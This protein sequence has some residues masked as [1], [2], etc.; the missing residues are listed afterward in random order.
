MLAERFFS[1]VV[2]ILVSVVFILVGGWVFALGIS[3]LLAVAAWE[4]A[5]LFLKSGYTPAR[6]TLTIG[7]FLTSLCAST[8]NQTLLELA[9]GL[10]ITAI[11]AC[12]VITYSKHQS[13]AGFDLSASLAGVVFITFI[14]SFLIR[15][16]FRDLGM[17]WIAQCIIPAGIADVGAL[18]LG[19]TLGRHKIAPELSPNK[20]V[21]GYFGGVFTSVLIGYGLGLYFNGFSPVFSGWNG[22]LI[23]LAVGLISPLG[24]FAKSIFKRQFGLKNTGNLIPGHGGVLDRIDTWLWAGLTGYF[25]IAFFF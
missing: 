23:G 13:T 17:L 9:F 6:W 7:T 24:D 16:R 19:S 1:G 2:I 18:L 4:Y 5:S 10:L 8:Q 12:H 15:L 25:I 14:G 22:L 11:V 3:A 21:E 20:T